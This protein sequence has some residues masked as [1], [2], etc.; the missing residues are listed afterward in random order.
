M[1]TDWRGDRRIGP[2]PLIQRLD[3]YWKLPLIAF[4]GTALLVPFILLVKFG[5]PPALEPRRL[6]FMWCAMFTLMMVVVSEAIWR[7]GL[8]RELAGLIV[9]TATIVTVV[10][11]FA[12]PVAAAIGLSPPVMIIPVSS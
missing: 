2:P 4:V 6:V 5:W 1:I 11:L 9:V 10:W 3:I 12:L 7:N 8:W